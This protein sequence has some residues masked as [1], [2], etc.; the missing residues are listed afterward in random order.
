MSHQTLSLTLFTAFVVVTLGITVW[1]S[2]QT[3]TAADFYS[4]GRRI[5]GWQ[6]GVAISGDYMS[7]ASFLG[8][9]GLISLFGYDGF[10]YSVGWLVAYLTVLILVAELLR[11]SG[12]YTMADV[13]AYRMRQRPVRSAA[14]L[15]TVGVSIFYLIAQMVGAGALVKLLLGLKGDT[16]AIAAIV[17]VGVLMIVYVTFGGMI[18]TTWVQIIKA[19]LLMAGT[20]LLSILVLAKFGFS[21]N[22]MF[23]DAAAASGKGDAFLR[24]GLR[25]SNTLELVSLGLALVLGTAGLPHILIRFYTVPTAQAAR[26]SVNWAIG[27]IGSFYIM[28]TFLGFGAAALV[29]AKTITAADKA[30]NMAG[31][32]LARQIGG[33]EGTFGGDLF[34]AFIAAVAFA[35]I[36]AVV[37][38]LTITASS[39]FA[40]DFYAN[41]VRRG[42]R[43]EGAEVRVA[44]I[45]A[46]FIGAIAIVL[47]SF[48]RGLNVAFL[49]GL[50]FAVAASANLPTI[51]FSLYWK[52]FNTTGAVVGILVG[53]FG[54]LLMVALGPNVIGPKGLMFKGSDPI[55]PLENPG[56]YSIPLGFIAAWAG[57]MLSRERAAEEMYDELRVRALTGLGAEEAEGVARA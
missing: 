14:A 35:T 23:A 20:L 4:A 37:A 19:L 47:A 53:L 30:G 39:S 42:E 7:A 22:K 54:C 52:R 8:I 49:V 57:T 27:I 43:D 34:L 17:G 45:T 11:N 5:S 21:M 50:A 31:P 38:G 10:L 1:A 29:G 6:N 44:R 16:A 40:H 13:L 56:I 48:A 25:F 26:K 3:K 18:G 9:A 32:L 24:P 46:L 15:S 2:R 33:G 41:V 55:F 36:L 28:T 12:K 51:L